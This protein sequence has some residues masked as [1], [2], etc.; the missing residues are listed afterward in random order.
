MKNL[1]SPRSYKTVISYR[2]TCEHTNPDGSVI[3]SGWGFS[4]DCDAEGNP[5]PGMNPIARANL[6][7]CKAGRISV[8]PLELHRSER[9]VM[10]PPVIRCDCGQKLTLWNSWATSCDCGREFNGSGQLLADRAQWGEET[11][12]EGTF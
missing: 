6:E 5:L 2:L 8:T 7:D 10:S 4:F 12:E 3:E 1:L 9:E 11:G